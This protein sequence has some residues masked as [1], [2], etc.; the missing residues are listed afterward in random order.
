[1]K[2]VAFVI[3]LGYSSTCISQSDEIGKSYK[4]E[5]TGL[6]Y[7]LSFPDKY[8]NSEKNPV[9]L[10]LHG[11]D[12]SNTKHHPS[13]YAKKEGIDFP[14]IVIAPHC[15]GGCSWSSVDLDGLINEIA[16]KTPSIS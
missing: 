7:I 16:A 13:K 15:T 12:R 8:N 2:Y 6:N 9:I 3:F 14:F 5:T 11:G 4:S 1:M 10:F